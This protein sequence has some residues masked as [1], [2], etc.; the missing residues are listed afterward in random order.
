MVWSLRFFFFSPL[1]VL[2]SLQVRV[3]FSIFSMSESNYFILQSSTKYARKFS[4]SR[5]CHLNSPTFFFIFF[6]MRKTQGKPTTEKKLQQREQNNSRENKHN[7][8]TQLSFKIICSTKLGHTPFQTCETPE[9]LAALASSWA[10]LL[11][12]LIKC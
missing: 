1:P 3:L 5:F 10:T 7:S 8:Y 4:N 6:W 12:L 11:P 9:S 2:E